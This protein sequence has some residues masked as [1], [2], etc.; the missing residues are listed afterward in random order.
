MSQKN[1]PDL[2]TVSRRLADHNHRV[3]RF[4]EALPRR[5]DK[6]VEATLARDWSEVR[7]LSEFLA[8]SSDIFG[9]TEVAQA[10]Q[11]VCKEVDEPGNDVAVK[12][13]V[14]RLIGSCGALP[15]QLPAESVSTI[16]ARPAE[17]VSP[18]PVPTPSVAPAPSPATKASPRPTIDT[19]RRARSG[20]K[21]AGQSAQ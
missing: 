9:C 4:V 14:I 3:A 16:D 19:V 17:A 11:R 10:A 13:S 12:R 18:S 1:L 8:C 7:H 6:L 15:E 2:R 5:V 20:R 21:V